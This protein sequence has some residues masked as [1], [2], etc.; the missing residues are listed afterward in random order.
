MFYDKLIIAITIIGIIISPL[1][2]FPAG[3]FAVYTAL[4]TGEP[5]PENWEQ[6]RDYSRF[7]LAISDYE[8]GISAEP[9]EYLLDGILID[10]ELEAEINEFI[11]KT[12]EET[13]NRGLLCTAVNGYMDVAVGS[14]ATYSYFYDSDV[15]IGV[16][17]LKTGERITKFSDL[18]YEGTDFVPAMNDAM[19]K[20]YDWGG[21]ETQEP[22]N[23]SSFTL[24]AIDPQFDFTLN[25]P[26]HSSR[27]TIDQM[28][29][30]MDYMPAWLYCDMSPFFTKKGKSHLE[31]RTMKEYS[32]YYEDFADMYGGKLYYSRYLTA[33]ETN[34]R[35]ADLTELYEA[36]E[37]SDEYKNYEPQLTYDWSTLPDLYKRYDF[38]NSKFD[39]DEFFEI[40][41]YSSSEEGF[42]AT[43]PTTPDFKLNGN[44]AI[45][46]T[47]FGTF[48]K[49]RETGEIFTPDDDIMLTV[50]EDFFGLVDIDFDG[51]AEQIS[52]DGDLR[53]RGKNYNLRIPLKGVPTTF[54]GLEFGVLAAF[55][56]SKNTQTGEIG[57][58]IYYYKDEYDKTQ[59]RISYSITDG[60]FVIT[61]ADYNYV[62][63]D[64]PV[65]YFNAET[66]NT[67]TVI[68]G[69]SWLTQNDNALSDGSAKAHFDI[70]S[71]ELEVCRSNRMNFILIYADIDGEGNTVFEGFRF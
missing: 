28:Y 35:N 24:T 58:D 51:K 27:T 16:W 2:N 60:K 21:I 6:T 49:N 66:E 9:E 48:F 59:S 5:R 29:E 39:E 13:G 32:L 31:T 46:D 7:R 45:V 70:L 64:S 52:F 20:C 11:L 18:F 37:N 57:G 38:P 12:M 62:A 43:T 47:P 26:Y 63:S 42:I 69:E 40:M 41:K 67:E 53:I 14:S 3:D 17:N 55:A 30:V 61:A 33:E 68:Y 71:G 10:K 44:I 34:K 54:G 50:K 15:V 23:Y 56:V 25:D 8:V 36:I 4:G 1:G 22:Q 19:S 65:R